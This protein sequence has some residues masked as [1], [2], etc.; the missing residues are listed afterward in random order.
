MPLY[1]IIVGVKEVGQV[2]I[3]II[4]MVLGIIIIEIGRFAFK[5]SLPAAW[6]TC[7]KANGKFNLN[8]TV[9]DMMRII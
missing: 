6:Q 7:H 4:S 9:G 2:S 8:F 1:T 5:F 3:I